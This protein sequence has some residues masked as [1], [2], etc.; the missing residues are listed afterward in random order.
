VLLGQAHTVAVPASLQDKWPPSIYKLL[1]N[2]RKKSGP[3]KTWRGI[4]T[5]GCEDGEVAV[6]SFKWRCAYVGA[7]SHLCVELDGLTDA[8]SRLILACQVE[9]GCRVT[10]AVHLQGGGVRSGRWW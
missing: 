7:W 3:C 5:Q 10:Q 8:L 2:M 9:S 6:C 4:A 1:V